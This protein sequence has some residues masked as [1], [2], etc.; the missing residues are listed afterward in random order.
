L[1]GR[2]QLGFILRL[3]Y[4]HPNLCAGENRVRWSSLDLA[5]NGHR[6]VTNKA[7]C[8]AS[9]EVF[10]SLCDADIEAAFFLGTFKSEL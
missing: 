10:D 9:T 6:P 4:L 5:V 7:L 1:P 2:D 8:R 3:R